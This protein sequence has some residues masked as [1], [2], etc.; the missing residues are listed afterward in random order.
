M[1]IVNFCFDDSRND[2]HLKNVRFEDINLLVG[3]SGVGK[4]KILQAILAL[5]NISNGRT[6]NGIKWNVEFL[7]SKNISY[8]WSGEFSAAN[9]IFDDDGD[10]DETEKAKTKILSEVLVC[11]DEVLIERKNNQIIY[12][13][14]EAPKLLPGKSAVYLLKEDPVNTIVTE[15]NKI[16]VYDSSYSMRSPYVLKTYDKS[17]LKEYKSQK[18]IYNSKLDMET[19]LLWAYE[20]DKELFGKIERHFCDIF[21]FIQGIRVDLLDNAHKSTIPTSLQ[22]AH[23]I[24][25]KEKN[26]EKWI[27]LFKIS[28]GMINTLMHLCEIYLCAK[29][30]VILIDELENSLGINCLGPVSGEIMDNTKNTQFIIT[31]HHPTIINSIKHNSWK[32]VTRNGKTVSVDNYGV[33]TTESAHDPYMQ[34]IN[35]IQYTDGITR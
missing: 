18:D 8:N 26:I 28:S 6:V 7:D 22:D 33:D 16:L 32:V 35:S 31:S 29:N 17:K 5:K 24:Q 2:W 1:K 20:N 10:D 27:P 3:L 4:T 14:K 23:F 30:S 12:N 13:G 19:R 9:E 15:M 25:I 34:L 21:P 11:N